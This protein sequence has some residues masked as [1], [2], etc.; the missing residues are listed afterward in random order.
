[1][2]IQYLHSSR[3]EPLHFGVQ[4]VACNGAHPMTIRRTSAQSA[5]PRVG[6]RAPLLIGG[7]NQ[8][9]FA[10]RLLGLGAQFHFVISRTRTS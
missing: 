1:M 2:A 9:L 10:G 8:G 6:G 3:S 5:A 7:H 4:G